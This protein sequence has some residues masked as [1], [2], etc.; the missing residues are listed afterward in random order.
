MPDN[1]YA[2]SPGGTSS[3]PHR[4]GGLDGYTTFDWIA[5]TVIVT[6]HL[7]ER[8]DLPFTENYRTHTYG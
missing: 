3:F 7:P 6:H 1:I 4:F 8:T 2:R 5:T